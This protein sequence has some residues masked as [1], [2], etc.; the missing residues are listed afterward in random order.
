MAS[1]KN[2]TNEQL[3]EMLADTQAEM[4]RRERIQTATSELQAVLK[5]YKLSIQDI[6]LQAFHKKPTRE[7]TRVSGSQRVSKSGTSDNRKRVKAKYANPNGTETWSG[8]GRAPAW[9]MEICQKE[10]V[11]LAE[12][13]KKSVWIRS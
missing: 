2:L 7:T 9:V 10:G 3:K 12:F 6:D 1:I 11:E 4:H 13:K 8:R 5:K